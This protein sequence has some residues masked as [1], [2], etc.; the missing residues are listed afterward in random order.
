MQLK[1]LREG[2][3]NGERQDVD[4]TVFHLCHVAPTGGNITAYGASDVAL[5]GSLLGD[6][7]SH[8]IEVTRTRNQLSRDVHYNHDRDHAF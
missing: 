7:P 8:F 4:V 6:F 1:R 3:R 5:E 2:Y